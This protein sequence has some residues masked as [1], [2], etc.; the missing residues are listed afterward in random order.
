M[1][2]AEAAQ[3]MLRWACGADRLQAIWEQ[4]RGRCYD[5]LITFPT[6]VRLV[7]EALVHHHGSGRRTFEKN[8]EANRLDAS[9]AAA[10]SK[11]GRL[12]LA[13]SQGFLEQTTAALHDIAVPA[14]VTPMPPSLDRLHPVFLD[15]KTVKRVAKRLKPLRGHSGGLIGGKA[16]VAVDARTGLVLAL[17]ADPDG[18]S[19]ENNLVP[20]LLARVRRV[21]PGPRLYIADRNFG[22]LVQAEQ[23]VE[24]GDHFLTRLPANRRFQP[25]PQRQPQISTDAEGRRIVESWGILGDERNRRSRPVRRIELHRKADEPTIVLVT[26]LDDPERYPATDLLTT[27]RQ[28]QKIESVFQQATEVFGLERL[29]GTTPQAGLF[30]FSF[31]LLLYNIVRLLL[32]YIAEAQSRRI[33]ELS[34]EKMF[35][36][37]RRQMIAWHTLFTPEQTDDYYRVLANRAD[38][39]AELRSIVGSAWSGTWM[40]T[41]PQPNR[42]V[43]HRAPKRSHSSVHR[44]LETARASK[45]VPKPPPT[46]PPRC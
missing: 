21:H 39:M 34:A 10:F 2:L 42:V 7:G 3:W 40:K 1:P 27:Y 41:K 29:I 6:L 35:D 36:D 25:D 16:L 46:R 33:A 4:H 45:P 26:D 19:S 30:Q 28:R 18:D 12:P 5:R 14:S 43:A 13:V 32:G 20:G 37:A 8:I 23:F 17:E 22:N 31:C 38:L 11:L 15:G 44:L 9:V 24:D